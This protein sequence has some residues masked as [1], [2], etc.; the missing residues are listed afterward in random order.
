[1][2]NAFKLVT[3]M[4][5]KGDQ[6]VAIEELIA[7]LERKEEHQVLLGATGTGKTFTIANV[8]ARMGWP[9]LVM[10]PNK[11]LAAQLY[12]EFKALFPNNAVEYF[13]SYYDYYQPEAFVASSNTYI[14]K[15]ATINDE[16]DRLR[17]SATKSLLTR[18]DVIIV[19]SVSCIYGIG[20]A[21]A[22][23][24][25]LIAL[26]TG[27][28][29]D[30][31]ALLRKLVE[32]QYT[33]NDYDFHRG[34][35]RVRGDVVEIFPVAEESL[36]IRISF[37]GDE[38]EGLAEI[39]PMR[40]RLVQKLDKV[41]IFPASHYVTFE[42]QRAEAISNIRDELRDRLIH[43]RDDGRLLEAQRL[44]DR[45]MY[46]LEMLEEIGYTTGIENYS[47]HLTGRDPGSPPPTLI[48]YLPK[49]FLCVLDES[50]VTVP[51][52][53]GMYRGDRSRKENLVEHGFRLP[54]AMDNRPLRFNEWEER[55]QNVLHVSATP[56]NWEMEKTS[57][58][59]V[60]QVVRPTG[61]LDPV[62]EIR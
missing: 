56:G 58:V 30:R 36:A 52:I 3:E 11:T 18:D 28:R 50:H 6:P 5:P 59:F 13:V 31:D 45:T 22:Y 35:F 15:D 53:G 62:I 25:L 23:G 24:G 7:G 1:M 34:T 40:G 38:V 8:I 20:S 33:R 10:A 39:D 16:I 12:G 4:T 54:S 37:W 55:V 26:V 19:A 51:Q 29:V 60:E 44:E 43:L 48:D 32:I 41:T 21:E 17:H 14:E 47:R 27:E 2:E 57:G 61:L 42:D 49:P 9:T 46:D